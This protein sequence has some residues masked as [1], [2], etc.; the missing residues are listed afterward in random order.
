MRCGTRWRRRNRRTPLGA[1]NAPG[2]LANR[3]SG[4]R[5]ASHAWPFCNRR[6]YV[7]R[8]VGMNIQSCDF[9]GT[10]TEKPERDMRELVSATGED[11]TL[12]FEVAGELSPRQFSVVC[13]CQDAGI[14]ND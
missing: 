6:T 8:A 11:P 12:S 9:A 2:M 4:R 14:A 10:R 7:R 5:R 1:R 3:E 13:A